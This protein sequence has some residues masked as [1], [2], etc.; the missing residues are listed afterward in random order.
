MET[1]IITISREFGSGGRKKRQKLFLA[2]LEKDPAI[3]SV[4]AAEDVVGV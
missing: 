1:K 4:Q 2:T 3:R